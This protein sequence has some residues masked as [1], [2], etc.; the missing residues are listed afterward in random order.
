MTSADI[1]CQAA[2]CFSSLFFA[3]ESKSTSPA[4]DMGSDMRPS[5]LRIAVWIERADSPAWPVPSLVTEATSRRAASTCL[6]CQGVSSATALMN[7]STSAVFGPKRREA[8]SLA[9]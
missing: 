3:S 1:A 9:R 8:S 6:H 2:T 7:A 5:L 4:L